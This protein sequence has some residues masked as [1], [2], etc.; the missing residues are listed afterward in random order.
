MAIQYKTLEQLL[1]EQGL[2][3]EALRDPG[4]RFGYG[5]DTSYGQFFPSFNEQLYTQ[6]ISRLRNAAS[7]VESVSRQMR[8]G[9]GSA[10]L[11]FDVEPLH[12]APE[13]GPGETTQRPKGSADKASIA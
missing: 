2:T 13:R 8:S 3:M 10:R 11:G 6:G 12:L 1:A 9:L 7:G 4:A 5:Q